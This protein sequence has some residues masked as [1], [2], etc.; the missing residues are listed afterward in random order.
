MPGA[1]L[2]LGGLL[3]ALS[4]CSDRDSAAALWQDYHYRLNNS[5]Q[6]QTPSSAEPVDLTAL[7]YP[8]RR[9]LR[10]RLSPLNV[11][12]LEFLRLSPCALQR[13]IGERNS[14]LGQLA[15]ASQRLLYEWRFLALAHTCVEQLREA[16]SPESLIASLVRAIDIKTAELPRAYW[17][18]YAASAEFQTLFSLRGGPLRPTAATQST[19]HLWAALD[20]GLA[21]KRALA[22]PADQRPALRGLEQHFQ[23]IGATNYAGQLS[24]AMAVAAAQL[25]VATASLEARLAP[26]PLCL[27]SRA[28]PQALIV[29]SVF[30]K[31]YIGKVQPYLANLHQQSRAFQGRLKRLHQTPGVEQ[32]GVYRQWW[33]ASWDETRPDSVW[34]SFERAL[35]DHTRAWQGLLQQCGLMPG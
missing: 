32:P 33:H 30:H 34:Q 17:N 26:R 18:A 29:Q 23:F 2:R 21:L 9:D 10:Q 1:L 3:L 4:G 5:L 22:E 24:S 12:L 35:A 7:R 31:Y 27:Q 8:V 6:I 19:A 13:L 28:T 11:N 25:A 14:S 20:D 16:E 15:P